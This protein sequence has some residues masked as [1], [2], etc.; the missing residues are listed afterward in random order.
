MN[1][2]AQSEGPRRREENAAL[3][4]HFQAKHALRRRGL[5][6]FAAPR[7]GQL[8]DHVALDLGLYVRELRSHHVDGAIRAE[9]ERFAQRRQGALL[10][11]RRFLAAAFQ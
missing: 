2:A 8:H 5:D 1:V 4:V 11:C 9:A 3:R 10:A 6:D 7:Q